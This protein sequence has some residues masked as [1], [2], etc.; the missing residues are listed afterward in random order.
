MGGH[1]VVVQLLCGGQHHE[2]HVASAAWAWPC[3]SRILIAIIHITP[4]TRMFLRAGLVLTGIIRM[5]HRTV[6]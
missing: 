5:R 6:S 4:L 1:E 3:N 2:E